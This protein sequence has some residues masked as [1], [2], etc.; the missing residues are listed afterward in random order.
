MFGIMFLSVFWHVLE[1]VLFLLWFI[2]VME[3]LC[4]ML[5]FCEIVYKHQEASQSTFKCQASS[6]MLK[7]AFL[8]LMCEQLWGQSK[9]MWGPWSFRLRLEEEDDISQV[10]LPSLFILLCSGEFQ[11]PPCPPADPSVMGYTEIRNLQLL[12]QVGLKSEWEVCQ[13][14]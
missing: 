7:A 1:V 13:R 10:S 3:W 8:F 14:Q 9:Y 4:L 2:T 12:R 11:G 5:V 6:L